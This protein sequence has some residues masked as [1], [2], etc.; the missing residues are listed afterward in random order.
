MRVIPARRGRP[1]I[2]DEYEVDF[3]VSTGIFYET[4]IEPASDELPFR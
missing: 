2:F 4:Q 3:K 1:D